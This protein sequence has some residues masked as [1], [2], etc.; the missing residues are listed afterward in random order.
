[1]NL[2]QKQKKEG[3]DLRVETLGGSTFICSSLHFYILH[4]KVNCK[5]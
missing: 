3:E 1:M 4:V 2:T 5:M